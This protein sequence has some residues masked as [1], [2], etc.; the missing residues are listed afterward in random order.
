MTAMWSKSRVCK[1]RLNYLQVAEKGWAN[2]H[3]YSNGLGWLSFMSDSPVGSSGQK[4]QELFGNRWWN[5][6]LSSVASWLGWSHHFKNNYGDT[7]SWRSSSQLWETWDSKRQDRYALDQIGCSHGNVTSWMT[8]LYH[9]DDREMVKQ[10]ISP[11][12]LETSW[13]IHLQH[14]PYDA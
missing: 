14:L 5:T 10:C 4:D 6:C 8:C 13:T 3:C 9:H 7:Q 11:L 12:N 1:L 2:G